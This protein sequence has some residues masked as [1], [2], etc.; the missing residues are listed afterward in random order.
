MTPD[1][2]KARQE[3]VLARADAILKRI[4]RMEFPS[5]TLPENDSA[6]VTAVAVL[7]AAIVLLMQSGIPASV[8]GAIL[9]VTD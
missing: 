2:L 8:S 5:T 9:G 1:E 6:Q 3:Q 4:G 7:H